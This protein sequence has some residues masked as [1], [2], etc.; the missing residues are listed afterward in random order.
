MKK[1]IISIFVIAG[2]LS[3][4]SRYVYYPQAGSSE[5]TLTTSEMVKIY[6]GNIDQA[7]T[8]L[9]TIAVDVRGDGDD[10][11]LYLKEKASAIGADAIIM[12]NLKKT[13]P[14]IKRTGITGIAIKKK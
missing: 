11:A 10:A 5:Q 3:S 8:V 9:G 14:Y 1:V 13:N 6:T 7:Y 4:C 12:V 2:I